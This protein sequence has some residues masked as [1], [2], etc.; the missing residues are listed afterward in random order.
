MEEITISDCFTEKGHRAALIGNMH[1]DPCTEGI[2]SQPT[3]HFTHAKW[4]THFY[5]STVGRQVR[6]GP[7][8]VRMSAALSRSINS[9]L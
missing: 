2:F 1:I 6:D 8:Q 7:A 9:M 4:D 3:N 5:C